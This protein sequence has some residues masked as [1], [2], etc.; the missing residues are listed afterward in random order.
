MRRQR[1]MRMVVIELYNGNV[2]DVHG[3][4]DK[5]I[6][7]DWDLRK[8]C[9]SCAVCQTPAVI[10]EC[11]ICGFKNQSYEHPSEFVE[12]HK[13]LIDYQNKALEQLKEARQKESRQNEQSG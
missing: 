9:G 8:G 10:D 6:V 5:Y 2:S 4:D 12:A 7:V 13:R 1:E 11:H 3:V